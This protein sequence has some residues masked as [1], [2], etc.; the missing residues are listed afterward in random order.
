MK[1]LFIFRRS[2][3]IRTYGPCRQSQICGTSEGGQCKKYGTGDHLD[4]PLGRRRSHFLM[5]VQATALATQAMSFFVSFCP[6]CI[7]DTIGISQEQQIVQYSLDVSVILGTRTLLCLE[8]MPGIL[9]LMIQKSY[10]KTKL[11]PS[12]RSKSFDFFAT[13][14]RNPDFFLFESS[15]IAW[16]TKE[17]FTHK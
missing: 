15:C 13:F 9:H 5:G 6:D 7:I 12:K 14:L 4:W 17:L 11:R 2:G 10:K 8:N 16:W 3:W 1:S